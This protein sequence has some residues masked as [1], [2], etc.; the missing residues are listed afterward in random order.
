LNLILL[1]QED[2]LIKFNYFQNF[3]PKAKLN[4]NKLLVI[5]CGVIAT[6]ICYILSLVKINLSQL[7]NG[8]LGSLNAPLIG[9]FLLS[10]FFS[11]TNKYG[12][13]A[14]TLAG[15]STMLW[16]SVGAI[17]INP[18]GPRLDVSIEKCAPD[19]IPTV[20]SF[21]ETQSTLEGLDKFYA[22]SY[23]WYTA[24]G[25]IVT[26]VSGLIVSALTGGLKN[27]VDRSLLI[28]DLTACFNHEPNQKKHL[29]SEEY[30]METVVDF[31]LKQSF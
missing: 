6:C 1:F 29:E 28:F 31:D 26:I 2:F 27:R 5:I 11:M 15:L 10:M 17:L 22:L 12:A 25:S 9:L 8:V 30:N 4:S 18:K 14:G 3:S 16:L 24:F 23:M 20:I 19:A 13:F 7:N 21:N